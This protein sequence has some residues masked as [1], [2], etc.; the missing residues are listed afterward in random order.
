MN[1]LHD[2]IGIY[3]IYIVDQATVN[4]AAA[5]MLKSTITVVHSM[6]KQHSNA[7]AN[8]NEEHVIT[9]C[10]EHMQ[11]VIHKTVRSQ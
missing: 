7:P 8:I 9:N 5:A 1:Q 10:Y 4:Q 3:K 2:C 6:A 11:T